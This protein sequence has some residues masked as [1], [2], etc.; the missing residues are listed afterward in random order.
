MGGIQAVQ[1][2]ESD[3][4]IGTESKAEQETVEDHDYPPLPKGTKLYVGN[5][6]FDIDS[7]GLAKMFDESG[8]F[9]MVEVLSSYL[10]II[11]NLGFGMDV[12]LCVSVKCL[13]S[14]CQ[15]S[16]FNWKS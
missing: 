11:T 6:P 16:H 7:E 4:A 15:I 13:S 10:F 9:K 8:V 2:E 14:V 5:I 3:V 12:P 1:E